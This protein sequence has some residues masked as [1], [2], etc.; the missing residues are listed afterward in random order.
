MAQKTTV[1]YTGNPDLNEPSIYTTQLHQKAHELTESVNRPVSSVNQPVLS[2]N[3]PAPYHFITPPY[4][5]E[6]PLDIQV[7]PNV[8]INQDPYDP[9]GTRVVLYNTSKEQYERL[10]AGLVL[11][12]HHPWVNITWHLH[13][14]QH[15]FPPEAQVMKAPAFFFQQR[16]PW[17]L[18]HVLLLL[19]LVKVADPLPI[20]LD[21]LR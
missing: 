10:K 17:N 7:L 18:S 15:G 19:L 13:F 6:D 1:R 12:S 5:E 2:V 4:K 16:N 9:E 21:T 3:Q 11:H 20:S 14:N 8:C